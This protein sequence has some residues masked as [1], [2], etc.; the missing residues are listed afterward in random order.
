MLDVK[1]P[2]TYWPRL[3]LKV[4]LVVSQLRLVPVVEYTVNERLISS[5]NCEVDTI[6]MLPAVYVP[7]WMLGTWAVD[8]T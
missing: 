2:N 4:K 6:T 5:C 8:V 7:N 3:P 1:F